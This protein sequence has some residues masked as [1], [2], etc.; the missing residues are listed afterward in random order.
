VPPFRNTMKKTDP[1]FDKMLELS[2]A[3]I[4]YLHQGHSRQ[5]CDCVGLMRMMLS[6]LGMDYSEFDVPDRPYNP[7]ARALIRGLNAAFGSMVNGWDN[8]RV[9]VFRSWA[10]GPQHLAI[11][12]VDPS[13]VP[14][15]LHAD[16]QFGRVDLLNWHPNAG[17]SIYGFWQVPNPSGSNVL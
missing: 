2:Q 14:V 1:W 11:C 9:V 4:P 13:G 16:R 12:G 5:G 10:A 17:H 8:H 6:E 7:P 15:L 3:K